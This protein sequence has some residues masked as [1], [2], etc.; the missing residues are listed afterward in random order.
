LQSR[1]P[2]TIDLYT[3][4]YYNDIEKLKSEMIIRNLRSAHPL[5]VLN[6][7]LFK[8]AVQLLVDS[9]RDCYLSYTDAKFRKSLSE[10]VNIN[11][12]NIYSR[13]ENLDDSDPTNTLVASNDYYYI[14]LEP[15]H[16]PRVGKF[17]VSNEAKQQYFYHFILKV[18]FG[19]VRW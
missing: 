16:D 6:D 17:Q 13:L 3:T 14:F 8:L 4:P 9:I 11:T 7:N 5:P 19:F 15:G 1:I 18:N 12:F 2:Q 10:N